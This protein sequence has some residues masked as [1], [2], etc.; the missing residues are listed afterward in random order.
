MITIKDISFAPETLKAAIVE[1][2]APRSGVW[3]DYPHTKTW[4]ITQLIPNTYVKPKEPDKRPPDK[5]PEKRP[6]DKDPPPKE[7]KRIEQNSD[8][9][10][11]FTDADYR[12]FGQDWGWFGDIQ[13]DGVYLHDNDENLET[14]VDFCHLTDLS[15]NGGNFAFDIKYVPSYSRQAKG[16]RD[17]GFSEDFSWPPQDNNIQGPRGG[18][19]EQSSFFVMGYEFAMR[20]GQYRLEV[21][22]KSGL[23]NLKVGRAGSGKLT[24]IKVHYRWWNIV[25]EA[26][27]NKKI[28]EHQVTETI[29]PSGK[30]TKVH[31]SNV[32]P[33]TGI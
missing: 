18:Y 32:L 20:E 22:L 25:Y 8:Q 15:S 4:D 7:R 1:S 14:T 10:E 16:K 27:G 24:S 31:K 30:H 6:P 19:M 3:K 23:G 13:T 9:Y 21:K 5:P 17:G 12:E 29:H 26:K 28:T 2:E 11:K 33:K